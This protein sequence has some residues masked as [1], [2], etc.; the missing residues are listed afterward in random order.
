[1]IMET[2]LYSIGHGRKS[3]EELVKELNSFGISFLID[4]RTIPYSKWSPQ[5][6]QDVFKIQLKQYTNIK[7]AWWGDRDSDPYIGGRPL[8]DTCFDE[9]GYFDY[10][11]MAKEPSFQRGL[12]R[13]DIAQEKGI[14]V[15]LMCSESDPSECHRS[16]L[17]GRELYVNYNINMKHIVAPY[18]I[19][20]EVEVIEE[21]TKGKDNEW[22]ADSPDF[23]SDNTM[24][25]FKSRKQYKTVETPEYEY[26][27]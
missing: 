19:K 17:I 16:K 24:P 22:R 3:F 8:D 21:L 9:Q 5:F 25:T 23:F 26:N 12:D 15:A 1:M 11:K 2:T 13:L 18:K 27:D 7:Y 10:S 20:T 4:V 6:N 14:K